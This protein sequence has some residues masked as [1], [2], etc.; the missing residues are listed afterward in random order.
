M[1]IPPILS[2]ADILQIYKE[3]NWIIFEP[4]YKRATTVAEAQRKAALRWFVEWL[5]KERFAEP[6]DIPQSGREPVII[7]LIESDIQELKKLAEGEG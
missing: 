1:E 5:E 3:R 4:D 7:C 6:Q 2:D